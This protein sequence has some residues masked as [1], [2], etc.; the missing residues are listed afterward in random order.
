MSCMHIP[1]AWLADNHKFAVD[2]VTAKLK[3]S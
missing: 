3:S 1:D 2:T